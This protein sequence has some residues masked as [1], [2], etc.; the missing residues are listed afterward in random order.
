M[1]TKRILIIGAGP[2]GL[3][4]AYEL[5]KENK[6]KKFDITILDKNIQVG[7]LARTEK[8]NR[9]LFDVGPHRFFTKNDEVLRLWK[10]VLGKKFIK[11]K[12]LTRMLYKNKLFLYPINLVDVILKLNS[13]ELVSVV[14]SFVYAKIF[15]RNLFPSTFEDHITNNF[16]KRMFNIFFKSYTEKVWGIPCS[17]IEA[18]WA[19]QRIKNL[20]L[21]EIIKNSINKSK[22]N[23]AKSLVEEFYYP[24]KGAGLM[25]E[26][27]A[28]ILKSKGVKIILNAEVEKIIN[29]SNKILS[30]SYKRDNKLINLVTD[31]VFS[32]MPIT[33][34][35][36]SLLPLPSKKISLSAKKMYFRDHITVNLVIKEKSLFNDN[37]IYVHDPNVKMARITNYNSMS[38]AMSGNKDTTAISVEYFVFKQDDLWKK[39]DSELIKMAISELAQV[40]LVSPMSITDGFVVREVD[41]YPVYYTGH[42]K[43]FNVVKDFVSEFSNLEL[44]GRGGMFKYNNMD[45]SIYSGMLAARNVLLGKRKYNPWEVNED[46]EYLETKK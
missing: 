42:E 43:Y 35:V 37:W 3:A 6:T 10:K 36:S 38:Q 13:F 2:A 18:K 14:I 15:L 1:K 27:M 23:K 25:Y 20:D 29:K 24:T 11:V 45:H 9:C 30:V 33:S 8:Y 32:S 26:T 41:S 28:K 5:V 31:F 12:R 7:G 34:F 19:S 21:W 17:Q 39:S 44:I 46:A 4:A 40:K 22:K 16:G